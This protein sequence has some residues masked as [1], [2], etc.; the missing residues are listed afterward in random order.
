[1]ACRRVRDSPTGPALAPQPPETVQRLGTG[2]T[3]PGRGSSRRT[4]RRSPRRDRRRG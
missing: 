3:A 2:I 4:P 1:V